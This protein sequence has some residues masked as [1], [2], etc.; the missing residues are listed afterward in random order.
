MHIKHTR[1]RRRKSAVIVVAIIAFVL[2]G[3]FA[4]AALLNLPPFNN[5]EK[6]NVDTDSSGQFVSMER[7]DTEKKA[8]ENLEQN[9]EQ[10]TQNNQND[11]PDSP[12]NIGNGKRSVNVLLTNA[13][14]LNGIVSA[15]GMVTNA[16]EQSGGCTYVFTNGSHRVTKSS[17]TLVNP[18][19]TTCETVSFPVSDLR[20]TGIW[21]VRLEYSSSLSEGSSTV[22]E[23]TL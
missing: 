14:V 16:T 21:T 23:F 13:G 20:T 7:T 2:V 22:K 1:K 9:P 17:S 8:S 3:Y 4:A 10:K 6:L 19:S 15:S 18:T 5:G 12:E 11:A